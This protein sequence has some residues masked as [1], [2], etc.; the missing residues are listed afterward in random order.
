MNQKNY[1]KIEIDNSE[2]DIIQIWQKGKTD[3]NVIQIERD[4][5]IQF[6]ISLQNTNQQEL[7]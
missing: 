3:V 7:F 4:K 6:I 2:K 5:L 1:P